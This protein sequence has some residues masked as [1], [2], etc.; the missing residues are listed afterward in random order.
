M[1]IKILRRVSKRW[2]KKSFLSRIPVKYS[3]STSKSSEKSWTDIMMR[4]LRHSITRFSTRPK[5]SS[6]KR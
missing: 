6:K 5:A 2:N 3:K 1:N 4:L